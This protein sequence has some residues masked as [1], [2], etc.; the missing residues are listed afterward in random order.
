[1]AK[2]LVECPQCE[3][4]KRVKDE[5]CPLCHGTGEV[6]IEKA[7]SYYGHDTDYDIMEGDD[8]DQTDIRIP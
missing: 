6:T 7:D 8:I 2:R 5:K 1:M 3:G 4:T